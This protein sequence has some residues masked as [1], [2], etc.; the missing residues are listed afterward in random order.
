M[1][2]VEGP[3]FFWE[4][5][6]GEH[7]K[8][9]MMIGQS[10]W[11]P[12]SR[13]TVLARSSDPRQKPAVQLNL[14]QE[15]SDMEAMMR[16]VRLAR[17]IAEQ[18]PMRDMI[19]M[20]ITPGDGVQSDA[21]LERWVRA[22]C[23]H[24]YHPSSSAR[25]GEPGEGVLDAELRVHG[26]EHLRVADTSALPEI[27]R[28]NTQAAA[29]LMGERC[30]AFIRGEHGVLRPDRGAAGRRRVLAAGAARRPARA[31]GRE[32]A[33]R[34]GAGSGGRGR[35]GRGGRPDQRGGLLGDHHRGRV[36]VAPQRRRA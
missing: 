1:Q 18:Q 2:L 32:P 17:L 36:R 4:H 15:R 8:P 35:G 9:A 27:P 26:V 23:Q 11:T 25:M 24:T 3:V 12:K 6:E 34:R 19:A 13:G 29:I 31:A 21:D 22:T 33:S 16:G 14:L 10:Y 20:E 7:P 5:G 30:A 28:G